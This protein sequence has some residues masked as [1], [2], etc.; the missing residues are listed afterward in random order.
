MIDRSTAKKKHFSVGDTIGVQA[1]GP[2]VQ[3]K[4]SGLVKFGSVGIG[5]ATL[6]GFDLPT[7][8]SL[9]DK[10]GAQDPTRY[11]EEIQQAKDMYR[12]AQQ[13]RGPDAW[14]EHEPDPDRSPI[15]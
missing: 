13:R 12:R 11:L 5:G 9:F 14:P 7:A 2:V 1:Q 8:Q 10:K 3:M 6:A 4:I 15:H